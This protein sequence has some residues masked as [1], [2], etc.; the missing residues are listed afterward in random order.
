MPQKPFES[1]RGS[2]KSAISVTRRSLVKAGLGATAAGFLLRETTLPAWAEDYP[3]L[4]TFPAG[5]SGSSIFIGGVMP[6]T[7][8]YSS[9]GKDMQLGFELAIEHL[10]NGSRV[11]DANSDPEKGQGCAWQEDQI[12]GRR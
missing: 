1:S 10:N 6:L 12:S 9:S 5:T 8:P 3:A 4:G 11:T 2:A 7:G